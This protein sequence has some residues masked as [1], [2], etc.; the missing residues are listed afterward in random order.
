MYMYIDVCECILTCMYDCLAASQRSM[1]CAPLSLIAAH[2]HSAFIYTS[3]S[4][5]WH[6]HLFIR[7]LSIAIECVQQCRAKCTIISMRCTALYCIYLFA[8][9]SLRPIK[10]QVIFVGTNFLHIKYIHYINK[11]ICITLSMYYIILYYIIWYCIVNCVVLFCV[12]EMKR[13]KKRKQKTKKGKVWP[14]TSQSA[15]IYVC[16]YLFIRSTVRSFIRSFVIYSRRFTSM[17]I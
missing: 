1:M 9:L 11:I 2:T 15:N 14:P 16:Q 13:K 12:Y 8:A 17:A 3:V 5:V 6:I 7:S 4:H 10:A